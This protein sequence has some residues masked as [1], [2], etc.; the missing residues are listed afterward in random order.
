MSWEPREDA[1]QKRD[2]V[3]FVYQDFSGCHVNTLQRRNRVAR[4]PSEE[5]VVI[6]LARTEGN[7]PRVV[8]LFQL[9]LLHTKLP[10]NSVA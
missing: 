7:L 9:L 2:K 6:I 3:C 1:K 5:T 10:Q 4:E 8:A